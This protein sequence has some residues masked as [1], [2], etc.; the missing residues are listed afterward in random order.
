M[1]STP[2]PY[3]CDNFP[4]PFELGDGVRYPD[5]KLP[6]NV[7]ARHRSDGEVTRNIH[8]AVPQTRTNASEKSVN[9]KPNCGKNPIISTYQS[10][11][12]SEGTAGEI[13]SLSLPCYRRRAPTKGGTAGE[14]LSLS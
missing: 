5:G 11:W 10:L 6:L 13:L 7:G 12:Q 4:P 2:C 14:I 1:L 9:Q 8:L 3:I